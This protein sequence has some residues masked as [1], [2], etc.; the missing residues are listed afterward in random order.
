MGLCY[1]FQRRVCSEKR[2]DIFIVQNREEGSTEVFERLV[3]KGAYSTIK[4]TTD[5]TSVLYAKE[6]WKEENGAELYLNSWMIKNN[7]SL[8]LILIKK[9]D[10]WKAAFSMSEV[11]LSQQ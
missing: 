9:G 10:K 6:E 5:I 1:R 3:K 8:P 7:Y 2:E 11:S 4:I